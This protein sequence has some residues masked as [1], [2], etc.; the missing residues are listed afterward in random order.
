LRN[1]K[2]PTLKFCR[3]GRVEDTLSMQVGN[4]GSDQYERGHYSDW[5]S[6]GSILR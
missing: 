2:I 5:S 6:I 3:Q 1:V 4:R